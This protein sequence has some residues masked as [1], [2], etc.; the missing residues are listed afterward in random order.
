MYGAFTDMIFSS[1]VFLCLFLPVSLLVYYLRRDDHKN[2]W[3]LFVSLFFF[4]WSRPA[5]L[6]IL[7][8]NILISYVGAVRIERSDK[9]R[10]MILLTVVI[11]DL[12]I[13][14]YF[15]YFDFTIESVNRIFGGS[16]AL[17][18]IALPTGISFFTFQSIS[19]VID[20][21]RKDVPA[22]KN[23]AKTGLYIA[24]F[25][26]LISGP[27]VRYKDIAS[28]MDGR[29]VT[30]ED[31][32][33][34]I[35]RFITG[36]GKKVILADTMAAL[37]D[38]V[39]E[40]GAFGNTFAIAWAGSIAYTLQIYYDF[41]GYSDM[42][43]G[44]G[45]MFGFHFREN[46]RLPY[47]SESITE[48]WRRWHISLSVW[49]RDYVYIPLG[50]NRRHMYRN[51]AVVFLLTGIWHGAA[52]HF[53]VWGLWHGA[54]VIIERAL[55]Q[56]DTV[57]GQTENSDGNATV[58]GREHA[59]SG[60]V[61]LSDAGA[62]GPGRNH[63]HSGQVKLSDAGA[64]GPDTE[65][66]RP[67]G[68]RKNPFGRL[69]K[70]VYTLLVVHLGW[71]LF[72]APGVREAIGYIAAMFGIVKPEKVGFT[73]LW[74]LDRWTITILLIGILCASSVPEKMILK[75]RSH[76]SENAFLF[77]KY[78]AL[79]FLLLLSMLKIVSGTYHPFIYYQF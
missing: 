30:R 4:A 3:L 16:F 43:I 9:L 22:Q 77:S 10:K 41:S 2:R 53:L 11:A 40:N 73:L 35:E 55:R 21:Y 50:G 1:T 76:V 45:R 19:Y 58:P 12:A 42:A 27:I 14:F 67:G 28:E 26:K 33:S 23:L 6:W 31:F 54:F 70:K 7:L 56:K 69:L 24:L 59:H 75:I 64:T 8:L 62:S 37:A 15:K 5:Y 39:W 71:V 63:A 57:P 20:V 49:F 29:T 17:R 66:T 74:Y 44:L 38:A 51:L 47:V 78:I 32:S 46:F 25:P 72:R 68:L 36:L 65:H 79:L 13:L 52:W 61:K 60:Q 34:G 48:F 18:D